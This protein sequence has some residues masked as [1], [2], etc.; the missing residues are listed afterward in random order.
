MDEQS[1]LPFVN[2]ARIS[3]PPIIMERNGNQVSLD[4]LDNQDKLAWCKYGEKRENEFVERFGSILHLCLNPAK[5]LDETEGKYAPDLF[6]YREQRPADLKTIT[7]PF[8]TA[9]NYGMNPQTTITLNRKDV[10]RYERL[11]SRILIY[12]WVNYERSEQFGQ[13]VD[14]LH[15][16]WIASFEKVMRLILVAPIHRYHQRTGL[17]GNAKDSYLLDLRSLTPC[18]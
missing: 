4:R 17:D 16:I 14:E 3:P 9:N 10:A 7:T 15:G 5:Q 1:K 13:V 12:F 18:I 8:Y 6:N 2:S 11:Y